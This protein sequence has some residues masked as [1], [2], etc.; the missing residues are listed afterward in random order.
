MPL[1]QLKY[2]I[3]EAQFIEAF[4]AHWKSKNLSSKSNLILGVGAISLGAVLYFLTN[5][6]GIL[7]ATIGTILILMVVLRLFLHRRAYRDNTKYKG[8]IEVIFTE[9]H[10]EVKS[11]EGES[12]LNWSLFQKHLITQNFILLYISQNTFSIIP[13]PALDEDL[14]SFLELIE[15]K[16]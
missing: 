2:S 8:E 3:S 14:E 7:L 4:E 16:I 6:G 13:K 12:K 15:N 11:T 1:Y 9:E 10:I 5:F